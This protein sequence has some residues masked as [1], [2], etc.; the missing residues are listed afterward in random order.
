MAERLFHPRHV[1]SGH[2]L[3]QVIG[4]TAIDTNHHH[5]LLGQPVLALIDLD[6]HVQ[7]F[8]NLWDSGLGGDCVRCARG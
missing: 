2:G 5:G 8:I 6:A 7:L 1:P 4:L 3:A